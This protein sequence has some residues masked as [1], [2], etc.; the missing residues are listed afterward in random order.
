MLSIL[1]SFH[2][3]LRLRHR[4]GYGIHSP[5]VFTLVTEVVYAERGY[6]YYAY[7]SLPQAEG[8]RQKDLRML[9]RL[10]NHFQPRSISLC[11]VAKDVGLWL[12]AGC[13]QAAIIHTASDIPFICMEREGGQKCI[14][15]LGRCNPMRSTLSERCTL[16]LDLIHLHFYYL[17]L[18]IPPQHHK[19]CYW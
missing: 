19:L 12:H 2:N 17:G 4:R 6:S 9:L 7:G 1:P 5:W 13:K 11:G 14:I 10:S 18:P 16:S 8:W 15:L 3:L